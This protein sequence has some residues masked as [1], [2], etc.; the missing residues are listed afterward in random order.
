MTKGTVLTQEDRRYCHDRFRELLRM[1][2]LEGALVCG[3]GA[4]KYLAGEYAPTW[5]TMILFPVQGEPVM[6]AGSPG[7]E[8]VL[9]PLRKNVAGYWVPDIR[10]NS[11]ESIAAAVA[12]KGLLGKPMGLTLGTLPYGVHVMLSEVLKGCGIED[13]T[14]P[15]ADLRRCKS[16]GYKALIH[17]AIDIVDECIREMEEKLCIG[18]TEYEVWSVIHH[19][20]ERRGAEG[21]LILINSDEKDISAPAM[22]CDHAPKAIRRGDHLVAEVT[23]NYRGCWLQRIVICAFG[24]VDPE[25]QKLHDTVNEAILANVSMVKPGVDSW[26]VIMAI[27]DY[28]EAKG[29]L[30][31][32]KDYISGPQ[33]HLSGYDLDE[34]CFAPGFVLREGMLFVLHP[35]AALPGWK[36]GEKGIF[37]PGMMFLVTA[38]GVEQLSKVPNRI[39]TVT[40]SLSS[41]GGKPVRR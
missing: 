16:G 17:E 5:G 1:R 11:A 37:G 34:G 26:K 25:I 15:F 38:D 12:E 39:V 32:R 20:M 27:D 13:I 2:G 22:A 7:R 33:G 41:G 28:I 3:D 19:V 29:F 23:V 36:E 10:L 21:A 14:A 8:Y 6:F 24:E 35:G 4:V 30:S 18:M 9:T 31:P 40:R